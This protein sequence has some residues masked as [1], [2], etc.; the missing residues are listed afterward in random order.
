MPRVPRVPKIPNL[1][2]GTEG[3]MKG[4]PGSLI[5][6]ETSSGQLSFLPSGYGKVSTPKPMSA[7]ELHRT[8]VR[9]A[10]ADLKAKKPPFVSQGYG[11]GDPRAKVTGL[12]R[13]KELAMKRKK[14]DAEHAIGQTGRVLAADRAGQMTNSE[15]A[16][17]MRNL[18]RRRKRS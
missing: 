16:F 10:A 4:R 14:A 9:G 11:L 2:R 15:F 17:Q 13:K 3:Y 5:P 12:A 6:S 7:A 8:V 1:P 18:M